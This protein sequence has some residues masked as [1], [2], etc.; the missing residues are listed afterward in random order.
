MKFLKQECRQQN[1]N[2]ND[3]ALDAFI[4]G[5]I[6]GL[7]GISNP[8]LQPQLEYLYRSGLGLYRVPLKGMTEYCIGG[9]LPY[10]TLRS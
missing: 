5:Q 6:L 2:I 1:I 3:V 10:V 9:E 4:C 7:I 8:K